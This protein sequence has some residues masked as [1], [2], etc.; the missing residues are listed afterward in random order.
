MKQS[1]PTDHPT[2]RPTASLKGT[3]EIIA[4]RR[5]EL[6]AVFTETNEHMR[7]AEQ[8]QLTVTGAYF[9]II[10]VVVSL[11]PGGAERVLRPTRENAASYLF[12]VIVGCCVFLYQAWCRVWKEHYLRVVCDIAQLWELPDNVLPYWLR[13]SPSVSPRLAFRA[14]VD[15]TFVYLTFALNSIFVSIVAFQVLALYPAGGGSLMASGLSALY[16][17]FIGWVHL[18]MLNKRDMLRA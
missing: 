7:N 13:E 5:E 17:L 9:G 11:L 14:H 10:A 16:L 2:D 12:M 6:L 18:L 15:N 4:Y 8:K 1:N 3:A